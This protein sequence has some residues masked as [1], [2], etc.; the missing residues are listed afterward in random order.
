MSFVTRRLAVL[1]DR[2]CRACCRQQRRTGPE[3]IRHR[4]HPNRNQASQHHAL[5]ADCVCLWRIGKTEEAY[6]RKINAA[7]ASTA[8]KINF[9]SYDDAY[10]PPKAVSR[11]AELVRR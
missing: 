11:R 3:E 2:F 5:S 8:R 9:I 1:F 7:A 4:R 6:F 10:S